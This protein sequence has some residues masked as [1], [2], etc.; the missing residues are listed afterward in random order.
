[1]P[2]ILPTLSYGSARKRVPPDN[3]SWA[4]LLTFRLVLWMRFQSVAEHKCTIDAIRALLTIYIYSILMLLLGRWYALPRAIIPCLVCA[5]RAHTPRKFIR[6]WIK[7][8]AKTYHKYFTFRLFQSTRDTDQRREPEAFIWRVE[9]LLN[10]LKEVEIFHAGLVRYARIA[11][12]DTSAM[13]LASRRFVPS[14][15]PRPMQHSLLFGQRTLLV[16]PP[17]QWHFHKCKILNERSHNFFFY[18]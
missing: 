18:Q 5:A 11:R 3:H 9:K 1:M 10:L 17:S 12:I 7:Q 13:D 15:T 8:N 6:H 14:A 4:N 16:Q 2:Q